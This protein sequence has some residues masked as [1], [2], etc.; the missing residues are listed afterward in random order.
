[1]ISTFEVMAA[2]EPRFQIVYPADYDHDYTLIDAL[3]EISKPEVVSIADSPQLSKEVQLFAKAFFEQV[4]ADI[5][6]ID[7]ITSEPVD[8]NKTHFAALE[9]LPYQDAF[10]EATIANADQCIFPEP[11][12]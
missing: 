4:R 12:D 7:E 2:Q 10:N 6:Q 5:N 8:Y 11:A 1:M 3:E 9:N